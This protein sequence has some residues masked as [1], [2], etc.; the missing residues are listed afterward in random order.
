MVPR[1]PPL[2]R[3]S[4]LALE[5][6]KR[7]KAARTV[8]RALPMPVALEQELVDEVRRCW[9]G[10]P[11]PRA[12]PAIL[13]DAR[14]MSLLAAI[15]QPAAWGD[16]PDRCGR[17]VQVRSLLPIEQA[18]QK[19]GAGVVV[20][21]PAFGAW[22]HIAPALARRGYRVGLLDL[23]P[24]S[25]RLPRY[26]APGPGLDLRVFPLAEYARPLVRFVTEDA[27]LLVVL[28]DECAGSHHAHGALLG[29]AATVGST[30]FELARR[31]DVPIVPVFCVR[32]RATHSLHVEPA[33]KV[34]DTGRGDGD[35]DSTASR[36]LRLL[37]RHA[38]RRPEHYLPALLA[39]HSSRYDDPVPLFSDSVES[40]EQRRARS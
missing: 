5:P 6:A 36:W 40:G 35:L 7:L 32:E 30:P 20:I 22:L 4:L 26:P 9:E 34:F 24:P 31:A 8:L 25:R 10:V 23:R 18:M 11:L 33:L 15:E 21:T 3:S 29:R 37:D 28:G 38:R 27:G 19:S 2:V 12:L 14:A 13:D 1:L 16:G 17:W 39:R